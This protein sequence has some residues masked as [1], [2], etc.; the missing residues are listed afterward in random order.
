M[1]RINGQLNHANG[2]KEVSMAR[3]RKKPLT[4]SEKLRQDIKAGKFKV[5]PFKYT[6]GMFSSKK[7]T[8]KGK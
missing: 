5:E 1:V 8:R 3:P 6:P 7:P 2:G 4:E